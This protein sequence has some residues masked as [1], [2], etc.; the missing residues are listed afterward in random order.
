M[1]S[2]SCGTHL[3]SLIFGKSWYFELKIKV[4]LLAFVHEKITTPFIS[5][6]S[7]VPGILRLL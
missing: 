2:P 5:F 1:V 6:P 4:G 7:P 3:F